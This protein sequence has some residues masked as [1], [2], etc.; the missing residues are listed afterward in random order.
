MTTQQLA[1]EPCDT[2]EPEP[3][4]APPCVLRDLLHQRI[5]DTELDRI[6]TITIR[7]GDVL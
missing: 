1:L 2:A 7:L 5:P 4:P 3:R 6:E